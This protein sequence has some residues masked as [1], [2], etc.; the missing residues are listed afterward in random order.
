[1]IN[2]RSKG[3]RAELEA[4][5]AIGKA[6]GMEFRRT[7][8]HC[9]KAGTAD[10][11]PVQGKCGIHWEVKH[12]AS[13]LTY[14]ENSIRK[15]RLVITGDLFACF[16]HELHEV[17]DWKVIVAHVAKRNASLENWHRQAVRDAEATAKLPVVVCRQD[18]GK[19]ILAWNPARD[20]A[21][22]EE[23]ERCLAD[24]STKATSAKPQA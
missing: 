9:G 23:V 10:I 5:R 11:E 24:G 17:I 20:T 14:L 15:H 2:S 1:M 21:F 19:W 16:L 6:L 3:A 13:G 12:Y 8:Q 22:M 18:R 4:A 7:A